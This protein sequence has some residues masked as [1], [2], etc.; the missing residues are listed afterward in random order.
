MPDDSTNILEQEFMKDAQEGLDSVA[1]K[2]KLPD[3]VKELNTGLQKKLAQNSKKK[4]KRIL[5]SNPWIYLAVLL[6]IF[7]VVIAYV[8]IHNLML[9]R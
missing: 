1:D 3:L 5:P 7:L 9:S 2:N 4:N 6:I 8:I